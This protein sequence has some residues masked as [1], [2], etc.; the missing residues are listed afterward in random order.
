MQELW[1][2]KE[3]DLTHIILSHYWNFLLDYKVKFVH[4]RVCQSASHGDTESLLT[5][6]GQVSLKTTIELVYLKCSDTEWSLSSTIT[7]LAN[8]NNQTQLHNRIKSPT[9]ER[10]FEVVEEEKLKKKNTKPKYTYFLQLEIWL[11]CTSLPC[12]SRHWKNSSA[13]SSGDNSVPS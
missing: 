12:F 13:F 10:G 2:Y 6:C 5:L 9:E 4:I 8:Y 7:S 3:T 11:V 1:L